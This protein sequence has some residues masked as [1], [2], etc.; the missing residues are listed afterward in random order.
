MYTIEKS[1]E[2]SME[3]NVKNV[4]YVQMWTQ[5]IRL[6][7]RCE[8]EMK[9]IIN[10][11]IN[12]GEIDW[13]QSSRYRFIQEFVADI[14][15]VPR[16]LLYKMHRAAES[17]KNDVWRWVLARFASDP[18]FLEIFLKHE[19]KNGV[20]LIAVMRM[21]VVLEEADISQRTSFMASMYFACR[22]LD[23]GYADIFFEFLLPGG[24]WKENG[25]LDSFSNFENMI[26]HLLER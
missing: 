16:H 9:D 8:D 22:K 24:K 5:G 1:L 23:I 19:G 26:L 6:G 14:E 18:F 3:T 25:V 21:F 12:T 7:D 2:V 15:E 20:L 17:D 4:P 11:R 13:E 10:P